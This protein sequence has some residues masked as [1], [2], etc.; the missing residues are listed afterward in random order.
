MAST[1]SNTALTGCVKWFDNGLNYGFI[2]VLSDGEH[3]N[4]D[5]FIH[6]SNIRTSRDCF[7]TLY[8]GECVQFELTTSD[9]EKHPYH[10]VNVSGYNGTLLHC[11]NPNYRPLKFNGGSGRGRGGF[12]G[13]RG[14]GNREGGQRQTPSQNAESVSQSAEVVESV[15]VANVSNIGAGAGAGAGAGRGRGRGRGKKPTT[16]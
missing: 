6:Q 3:K 11:E 13:G 7:R 15:P 2:T 8:T 4:K 14:R 1:N 12:R 10:A 9:N 5:I 16:G